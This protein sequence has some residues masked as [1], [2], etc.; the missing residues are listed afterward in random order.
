ME[1][2]ESPEPHPG[3]WSS[4]CRLHS[5]Q[6]TPIGAAQSVP[7]AGSSSLVRRSLRGAS[8]LLPAEEVR[9]R[10]LH[11]T[12]NI[13]R[14]VGIL[15]NRRGEGLNAADTALSS[16]PSLP[17]SEGTG[18]A[19]FPPHRNRAGSGFALAQ[20]ALGAPSRWASQCHEQAV[21]SLLLLLGGSEQGLFQARL[22]CPR[23]G[24]GSGVRNK[25]MWTESLSRARSQEESPARN[26][27]PGQ[28]W[29]LSAAGRQG[30]F[31]KERAGK[32]KKTAWGEVRTA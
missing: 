24:D 30:W 26:Q 20:Q 22:C 18:P 31:R 32:Q 25:L 17:T 10:H 27:P 19:S 23:T 9:R 11:F 3:G 5:V 14:Q 28:W 21:L 2:L 8:L 6:L 7:P 13:P 29:V 12:G 15:Q 16:G 1:L 4:A